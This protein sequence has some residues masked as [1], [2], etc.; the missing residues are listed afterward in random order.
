MPQISL[1]NREIIIHLYLNGHNASSIASQ[2]KEKVA[3]SSI[4]R[5][6]KKYRTTKSIKNKTRKGEVKVTKEIASFIAQ[7]C[8][9]NR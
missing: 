6:I 8:S 2:L 7:F 4:H 3:L 5:L 1:K 9:E